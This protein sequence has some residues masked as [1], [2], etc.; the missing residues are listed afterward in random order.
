[1]KIWHL[2]SANIRS[3][4]S[5][6]FSLFILIVIAALLLN[7]GLTVLTKMGAFFDEKSEQLD[8]PHI[9]IMTKQSNYKPDYRAYFDNRSEV[10][11]TEEEAIILMNSV[12]FRY[13]DNDVSLGAAFLNADADRTFGPIRT[14][15]ELEGPAQAGDIFVPLGFQSSAGYKLGDS[16]EMTYQGQ[17]F[18]YRIKGFYETTMMGTPNMGIMKYFLPDASYRQLMESAGDSAAGMLISAGLH[19][20]N[21]SSEVR[22]AFDKQFPDKS[23]DVNN[24]LFWQGDSELVKSVG[25][26]TI[27]V[28]AMI[29]VAFAA[30]IV[31]VSL[32][33]IQ[34]RVTNS[35]DDGIVNIGVLK[36]LGYTSRQIIASTALQFTLISAV[37]AI[38]GA[39]L[40]YG[41][42]PVFG[43]IVTTL[44][45]L[46]WQTK[47]DA[48]MN[49]ASL[50]VVT[51]AVLAVTLIASARIRSLQ[52]VTALRGGIRTHSFLR[53]RFPLDRATGGLQL[54][55]ACKAMIMNKKQNM[56]VA[57]IIAAITFASIFSVVLYYNVASDK[58]AFVHLVGAETSNVIV[59]A[60]PDADSGKLM[61][62]INKLEG[63]RKSVIL[64]MTSMKLDGETVFTSIS[65]D[66]A[67]LENQS[68]YEGR[69]PKYDNEIAVTW[70]VADMLGKEVGDTIVAEAGD[71]SYTYLITGLSQSISNLGQAAYIT[72]PGAQH[73][74][75]GYKGTSI[76][77]YLDG[78][79]NAGFMEQIKKR[80]GSQVGE[81][82]DMDEMID[83]QTSIYISAVFAVMVIVLLITILVVTLILY[84]VIKKM[85]V[86]RKKELG[87]LKATGYTTFQLMRQIALSF[88]PVVI[89]G[90]LAGGVLGSLFTNSVLTLL[91]SGAGIHKVAFIVH[92][93][94]IALI[95]V[96]LIGLSYGVSMLVSW[97]IRRISAYGLITE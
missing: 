57:V 66:F 15:E 38:V 91:L 68:V 67:K 8:E 74:M 6:A 14:V 96:G 56:M 44:S 86:K 75:P 41:V 43:G 11:A 21:Q 46:I 32:M 47:F 79:D 53:N 55:L 24:P 1:M 50:L 95:C 60:A 27:N 51:L 85:I 49:G 94:L 58:T 71:A 7:V 20:T 4:K 35:I 64:D 73:I 19:D 62:D 70:V 37:A 92:L 5:A 76:N 65:D 72:I 10:K 61:A 2:T 13:G 87:I 83:G 23:M 63:V 28:V 69:Y 40:S 33:V 93:P 42:L 16:F 17:T 90:V 12:K 82:V 18:S 3:G 30:V 36:A 88:V 84:L 45:G 9:V 81:V 22:Q 29:L 59:N 39:A 80:F 52:P 77:V 34:F 78:A 54:L 97:G 31:L 89:A 26:I 25:S 48:G